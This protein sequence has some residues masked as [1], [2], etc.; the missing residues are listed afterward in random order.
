V[1]DFRQTR[2]PFLTKTY[3]DFSADAGGALDRR[4]G[5]AAAILICAIEGKQE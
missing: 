4:L 1:F 3:L 2:N 5:L